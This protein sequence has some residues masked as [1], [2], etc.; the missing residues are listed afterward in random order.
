MITDAESITRT[1][2][3]LVVD[4][5]PATGSPPSYPADWRP[6]WSA[7]VDRI[8][9]AH[10]A[11]T[12]Q[13]TF[14]F[15]LARWHES[16]VSLGDMIRITTDQPKQG[17]RTCVFSGFV[18]SFL[19]DFSGGTEKTAA[20]ERCAVV[21]RDYRWLLS[22]TTPVFGQAIRGPDDYTDYGTADQ[23]PI[24]HSFRMLSGRRTIFNAA[25]KPNK[26]PVEL[27]VT[28]AAGNFLC[29][30]PIFAP[31][32]SGVPWSARDMIRY[33]LS[34]D[35]NSAYD[36]LTIANPANLPGLSAADFDR[37]INH[38]VV[39]GLDALEA[40]DAVCR[41]I[42]FSF[43][44]NYDPEGNPSIVFYKLAAASAYLRNT[45]NPTILHELYAPAVAGDITVPIAE[46]KKMLW[47]MTLAEDIARVINEPW[48]IGAPHRFEF[49]AELVPAWSDSALLPD[50]T[51]NLTRLYK[52]DAD[53][54]SETN[55]NSFAFFKYYHTRGSQ[56]I[57]DVGRKW[58]LNET[59]RYSSST[60]DRGMPFDFSTVIPA[61]YIYDSDGKR[62]YAAVAR[63]LLPCLTADKD[64]M[65]TIGVIVEFSF[66]G[67]S[68]WQQI[69]AAPSNLADEAGIRIEQPNLAEMVD[70][71]EGTISGGDLD[72]VQLNYWTSLCGDKLAG[73]SFKAGKWHTRVRVTCSVQM[74]ERLYSFAGPA[75]YSGSPFSHAKLFDFSSKYRLDHRTD[76]STMSSSGLPSL[77]VNDLANITN[78][79]AAIRQA[80]EDMSV[81][82]QFTLERLWLGD[83]ASEPDF[84]CGDCIEE[85]TG[86]GYSLKSRMGGINVYPEIIK[87]IYL[88]E[89][90]MTKLITRDLRFAEVKFS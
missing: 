42:G 5:K 8:E 25:G 23:L 33:I 47:S 40:V 62:L 18:T 90:Q 36:Y 76:S 71:A 69:P 85:I 73:R 80:N 28:D 78:H 63:K 3:Q 82:G 4:Y 79:I 30:T 57:R 74:D 84:A 19:S 66:D 39:D 43:R 51:E 89:K 34:P 10:G 72:G 29:H 38:V 12:S 81:S 37:V 13:A 75:G 56:F 32:D 24:S 60:Y 35:A 6:V 20:H 17:D 14:W 64:D 88:P 68:T 1:A 27:T 70:Q 31:A 41:H 16:F 26:D 52:I 48:G 11:A 15:P 54:Q 83:G 9:I 21:C 55:P 50:T 53:L 7:K 87:I 61:Q 44:E 86:R 49:T 65:N 58:A 77:D 2:Q 59:G 22:V 46:G 45:Q 67:G